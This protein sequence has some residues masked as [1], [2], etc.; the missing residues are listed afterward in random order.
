MGH[1][2][3]LFGEHNLMGYGW[4]ENGDPVL[5]QCDVNALAFIFT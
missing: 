3:T 2:A 4:P 5:S 1:A